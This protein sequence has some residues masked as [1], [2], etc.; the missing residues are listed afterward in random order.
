MAIVAILSAIAMNS[1]RNYVMRSN[2]AE[3]WSALLQVQTNE[4][5]YFLQN[6][7]YTANLTAA[8]TAGGLGILLNNTGGQLL[9]QN[10]NYAVTIATGACAGGGGALC[11]YTVTA[12]AANNQVNDDPRPH[13]TIN[14]QGLRTPADEHGL[15]ALIGAAGRDAPA[16]ERRGSRPPARSSR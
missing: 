13:L 4:E 2:R 9:T 6:N 3:A 14:S 10:N 11:T 1:Y 8:M 12:T 5:K 15:L 16:Q 7:T